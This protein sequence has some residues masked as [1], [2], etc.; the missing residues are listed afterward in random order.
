MAEIEKNPREQQKGTTLTLD[1]GRSESDKKQKL[2]NS[3]TSDVN[4]RLN[5]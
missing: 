3:L 1:T 4:F 5:K 2:R